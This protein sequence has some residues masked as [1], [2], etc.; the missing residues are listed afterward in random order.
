[1]EVDAAP[2]VP[3]TCDCGGDAD[4]PQH[5]LSLLHAEWMYRSLGPSMDPRRRKLT[6]ADVLDSKGT[7]E[8]RAIDEYR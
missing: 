7:A 8:R 4:D 6:W 5:P 3:I 2:A 1:M